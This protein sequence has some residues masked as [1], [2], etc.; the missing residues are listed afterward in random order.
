DILLNL[1]DF[2]KHESCG[3]CTPCRI[4][5]IRLKEILMDLPNNIQSNLNLLYELLETMKEASLC[6][7][8]G[9][10]HLSVLSALKYFSSDFNIGEL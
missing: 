5:Q 1:V 7:L 8:G 2:Y 4:G 10:T 9:L 6:G 3:K